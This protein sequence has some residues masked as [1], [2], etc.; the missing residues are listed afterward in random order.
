MIKVNQLRILQNTTPLWDAVKGHRLKIARMR[1]L[2]DQGELAAL[3]GVNQQTISRIEA[4]RIVASRNPLSTEAWMNVLKESFGFVMFGIGITKIEEN[5][6]VRRF[7]DAKL[8][9][10]GINLKTRKQKKKEAS[11]GATPL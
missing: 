4:G 11:E 2:L 3:L 6:V 7:W 8:K 9:R 10:S 5:Y 1:V